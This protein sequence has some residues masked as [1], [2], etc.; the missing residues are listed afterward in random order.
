[1]PQGRP[2]FSFVLIDLPSD[3]EIEGNII[4]EIDMIKA[5]LHNRGFGSRIKSFRATNNFPNIPRAYNEVGFVH[6]ATHGSEQ[7]VS[8]IGRHMKWREVADS[9]KT[10]VPPLKMGQ[11][12]IL[13]LSC[14]YS[15][16]GYN[17]LKLLLV[18]HFTGFYYF[19]PTKIGFATAM[20][21]WS[22]FYLK[23]SIEKPAAAVA[24]AINKFF[25]DDVLVYGST[26]TPSSH[27]PPRLLGREILVSG[28]TTKRRFRV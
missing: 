27:K 13:S 28:R 16:H 1:M 23:K 9:L 10:I 4:S 18:K 8:L 20:T 14:C 3:H 19:E 15:R 25:E 26:R 6:L 12:R 2:P 21:V 11:T 24:K 5:L 22:M 7:G 17:A